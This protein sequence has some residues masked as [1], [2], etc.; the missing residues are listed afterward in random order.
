MPF[1]WNSVTD[2]A[3]VA[4]LGVSR[5]FASQA[6]SATSGHVADLTSYAGLAVTIMAGAWIASRMW[7]QSRA[8]GESNKSKLIADDGR[9]KALEKAENDARLELITR[10]AAVDLSIAHIGWQIDALTKRMDIYD[11]R[12]R[13]N[14]RKLEH[15]ETR[16]SP[17]L[18]EF[19][20]D[21]T[22]SM[23]AAFTAIEGEEPTGDGRG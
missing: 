5:W 4:Y 17:W 8:R 13:K 9:L 22:R 18:K 21:G 23:A 15:L 1:S 19:E 2:V 3:V 16:M 11:S 7:E 6:A 12:E 10:R 14:L 20:P